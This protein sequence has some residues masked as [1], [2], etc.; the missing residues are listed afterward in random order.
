MRAS[1]KPPS[2]FQL[3]PQL[4]ACK[5]AIQAALHHWQKSEQQMHS[6]SSNLTARLTDVSLPVYP[7]D[8]QRSDVADI[9]V[10]VHDSICSAIWLVKD[11]YGKQSGRWYSLEIVAGNLIYWSKGADKG[12]QDA[13]QLQIDNAPHL[14][15]SDE[16][17]EHFQESVAISEQDRPAESSQAAPHRDEESSPAEPSACHGQQRDKPRYLRCCLK[18]QTVFSAVRDGMI[19]G[20]ALS[21]SI[22]RM[23]LPLTKAMFKDRYSDPEWA[24]ENYGALATYQL[25]GTLVDINHGAGY[26]FCTACDYR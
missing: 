19:N 2:G 20:H 17:S 12:R 3:S 23:S 11:L 10:E 16:L 15:A 4:H 24:E 5:N 7:S 6:V 1:G 18:C 13:S 8:K 14:P 21:R 25:D 9:L 22:E 26:M